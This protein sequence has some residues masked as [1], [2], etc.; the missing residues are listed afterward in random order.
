MNALVSIYLSFHKVNSILFK[1]LKCNVF[2]ILAW[3]FLCFALP[4]QHDGQHEPY[5]FA[6][7]SL[8]F[9]LSRAK[10]TTTKQKQSQTKI[11]RQKYFLLLHIRSIVTSSHWDGDSRS[12]GNP[13]ELLWS[14]A[15]P[16][17]SFSVPKLQ[18]LEVVIYK[19]LTNFHLL[20]FP[21]VFFSPQSSKA[22]CCRAVLPL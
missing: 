5:C 1:N 21:V 10:T 18:K 2:E 14:P 13:L 12:K 22:V 11:N 17:A 9:P 19:L 15:W 6:V 20:S 16:H 8:P 3:K 4:T 7:T